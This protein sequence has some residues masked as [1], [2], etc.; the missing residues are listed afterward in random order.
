[1]LLRVDAVGGK[2]HARAAVH[3][4]ARWT[5]SRGDRARRSWCV[6]R[7]RIY[8]P[9]DAGW[10]TPLA[11]SLRVLP[12]SSVF[13]APDVHHEPEKLTV[14]WIGARQLIIRC[15]G[16]RDA[17]QAKGQWRDITLKYELK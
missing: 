15:L 16:C 2:C 9:I 5:L 14:Q 1:M 6:F 7:L 17:S 8:G 10:L 13:T 11:K 3:R 4:F 12:F